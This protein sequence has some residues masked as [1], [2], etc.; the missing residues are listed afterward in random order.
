MLDLWLKNGIET[1]LSMVAF[2]VSCQ[3][4]SANASFT[5]I[6]HLLSTAIND[7]VK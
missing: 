7:A 6:I 5:Y 4:H 3:Y 2:V 1:G